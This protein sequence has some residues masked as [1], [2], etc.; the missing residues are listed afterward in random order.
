MANRAKFFNT[1]NKYKML[2]LNKLRAAESRARVRAS[3]AAK[4]IRKEA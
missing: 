4:A 1:K 3:E 2:R